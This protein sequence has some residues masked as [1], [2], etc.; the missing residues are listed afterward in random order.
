MIKVVSVNVGRPRETAVAGKTVTTGIY[1]APV[2]GRVKVRK[3]NL[4][5]DAQADLSVHGGPNKAVYAYPSE[6]YAYW[7]NEFPGMDLPWGMFGENLTLEGMLEDDVHIGDQFRIGTVVLMVTQPRTPCYKLGIRF[8]R[9]D[10][11]DRFLASGRTGYYLAIVSEGELGKDDNVALVAKGDNQISI[12]T[13]HRLC[14]SSEL[15]DATLIRRVLQAE[16]LP[17]GWR[18]R[19]LE[20][21]EG[22]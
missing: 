10:V 5:G 21:L 4:E 1:K 17:P 16:A 2:S 13:L 20:L 3:H 19:L 6:H 15:P 8:G 18:K 12:A 11:V 9:D 14:F 22:L 7:K